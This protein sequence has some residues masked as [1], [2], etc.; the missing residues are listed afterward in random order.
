MFLRIESPN[1]EYFSH[2]ICKNPAT[3]EGFVRGDKTRKV[4]GKFGEQP[5]IY[6]VNVIVDSFAFLDTARQLNMS[7][8]IHVQNG[9]VCPHT[10]VYLDDAFRSILRGRHNAVV[11]TEEQYFQKDKFE[12]VMGPFPV[13]P[14]TVEKVFLYAGIKADPIKDCGTTTCFNFALGNVE[15]ITLTEFL[16]KLYVLSYYLTVNKNLVKP[17]QDKI[18]LFVK[19]SSSWLDTLENR[20]SIVRRLCGFNKTRI[21]KFELDL[22]EAAGEEETDEGDEKRKKLEE[23]LTK[24]SLH[25]KRHELIE[26]TLEECPETDTIVDLCCGEGK[27]IHRLMKNKKYRII[28][29]EANP[30]KVM[31]LKRKLRTGRVSVFHSNI[32]MPD[33]D[34]RMIGCDA[35]ICCEMLE[36]FDKEERFRVLRLVRDVL[37]PKVVVLTTPNVD[38]NVN[39]GLEGYRHKDHKI[40]FNIQQFAEEVVEYLEKKYE[41]TF[42][43]LV[44][45]DVQPT[46][47]IVC[48]H[49]EPEDRKI[50]YK[51]VR[52][53]KSMYHNVYLSISNY[54]VT[55]RELA[56]GYSNRAYMMNGHDIFY[57]A[58]TMS[59]VE[60]TEKRPEY[61]EHPI[62]CFDYY[63]ERGV[64]KLVEERKYMGS[65]GEIL[66]FK[67]PEMAA[68]MGFKRPIVINSR[69]GYPFFTEDE[70][71]MPIWEEAKEFMEY[72]FCIMDAEILP[73]G[74][75]AAGLI[76]NEFLV[77]LE[78]M[79]LARVC[80]GD[81]LG[82][83]R[84]WSAIESVNYYAGEGRLI[85]IRPFHM[86]AQGGVRGDQFHEVQL[87]TLKGHISH[88]VS[89]AKFNGT[90]FK[91]IANRII[92]ILDTQSRQNSIERWKEYCESEEFGEGFVYKPLEFNAYLESGYLIQPAL[93]VRGSRY[94][95]IIYG[96]DYQEPEYLE[97]LRKR[98]ISKK[99]RMA[100][101]QTE[102]GNLILRAFLARNKYNK[103]KLVAAFLGTEH[104]SFKGIDATL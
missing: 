55:G 65:R 38:Y 28:G 91:P 82:A 96:P 14:E 29:L 21:E 43:N 40:E 33:L 53:M 37:V 59:P 12:A 22:I 93:K 32:L 7:N 54:E 9:A 88:L 70:I 80:A 27:L 97:F 73:W 58:P 67:T 50:D 4:I 79:Y 84:A 44:E 47:C 19:M 69:G 104:V 94:L 3:A 25:E 74:I 31:K 34:D 24:K 85:E 71:L 87:G 5:W 92:D 39:Y 26:K 60:W 66:L 2:Q 81:D 57:M 86:L 36:H 100:V 89:L 49:K 56:A 20:N 48:K 101:Q 46:F 102:I 13:K 1:R 63:M 23:F 99:R 77:P 72:D 8:Y 83:A 11:M 64:T 16:Q 30:I 41:V 15:P 78:C 90:Y 17:T 52:K 98:Y 45:E 42:V 103:D 18:E 35:V 62:S 61:L 51:L 75:K 76:I 10:L 68:A 95:K 6:E